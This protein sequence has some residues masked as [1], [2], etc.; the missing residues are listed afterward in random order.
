MKPVNLKDSENILLAIY[1]RYHGVKKKKS[2]MR[3]KPV[4]MNRRMVW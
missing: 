4:S 1:A 2:K 3:V